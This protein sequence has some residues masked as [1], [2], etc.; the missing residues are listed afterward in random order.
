MKLE[1][2]SWL[3]L[4]TPG[5]AWNA[6][7][8]I[9]S[10]ERNE[11][12]KENVQR[13]TQFVEEQISNMGREASRLRG[14]VTD[15]VDDTLVNARRTARRG[16]NSAEDLIDETAH[17]IRRHPL[18]SVLCALAVGAIVGWLLVPRRRR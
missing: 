18:R 7:E 16:Y 11:V 4:L 13:G 3:Q 5:N 15:A 6:G 14:V 8:N 10:A 9:G 1:A 17:Q 12:M 2:A